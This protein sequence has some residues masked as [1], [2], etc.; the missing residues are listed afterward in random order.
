MGQSGDVKVSA[1]SLPGASCRLACPL[2]SLHHGGVRL[3]LGRR[4][5]AFSGGL[6]AAVAGTEPPGQRLLG[7][8][9]P[10][11]LLRHSRLAPRRP[12]AVPASGN[13]RGCRLGCGVWFPKREG[14][15]GAVA[16]S[17]EHRDFIRSLYHTLLS[18]CAI[19]LSVA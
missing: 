7:L 6:R 4:A 13:H 19:T 8:G 12:Q 1:W 15:A 10:G 2:P 5:A 3:D 9:V 11:A 17:Q 18:K 14:S 16:G